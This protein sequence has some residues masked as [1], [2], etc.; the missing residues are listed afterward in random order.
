MIESLVADAN[1]SLSLV[2]DSLR[3]Q[4]RSEALL[5]APLARHRRYYR[6]TVATAVLPR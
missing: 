2:K 1:V 3:E 5:P 4:K 6:D